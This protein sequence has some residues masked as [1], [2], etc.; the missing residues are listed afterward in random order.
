MSFSAIRIFSYML[1]IV[2]AAL[3]LPFVV[4]CR[5]GEERAALAFGIPM[6]ASWICA[7]AFRW[8][9][10]GRV[11]AIGIEDAFLVVGG[12]WIV[13]GLFG[14]LPFYLSGAAGSVTDAVF[15]SVS[16]FT[17][18][19]ATVMRDVEALPRCV[20]LWRCQ[21]H[22]L[23]GMGV[24]AL[25]VALIPLLG[26][27]GFRMIKAETTG[28]EKGKLTSRIATTAKTLWTV[29]FLFTLA[30]T[31]LLRRFGM[32][33]FDA[34]CHAFSTMGTGGFSTYNDSVGHFGSA[35]IDWTCTAFMLLASVNFTLYFNLITGRLREVF[36]DSEFR[37]FL[38]IVAAAISAVALV[39]WRDYGGIAESLRYSSFQVASI[40]S[41]TGFATAD[42]VQW[43]PA[44]QMAL[45][46][47]FL[48]GGCAGSTAGGI[49][50]VRWTIL[51]KQL[52]NE[53]RRLLHPHE[54][55]SIRING[56]AGRES[57]VPLVASF[58]FVYVSLAA[59]TA[60]FGALSGLGLVEALSGALSMVGNIGPA[61]GG[62]GPTENCASLH[63]ALKWWYSFVMIAGRLEIY[64][65]LILV[66]RAIRRR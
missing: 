54:V 58:I 26:E 18:T 64:T 52:R 31:L 1:A 37:G 16:G 59:V 55:M 19:G 34:V 11:R 27:G 25:A 21:T 56:V 60:F 6:A 30:Q 65:L 39:E 17:T 2:G 8:K 40:V 36:L 61:F 15:E 35:A 33:W 62:L 46:L 5:Y 38:V 43:C 28:P 48:V 4:G 50:V 41:T 22:W 12:I 42:Y 49:K 53:L 7:L 57:F 24:I 51:W 20:N 13:I 63:W 23:G 9:R 66:G 29:Y 44:A 47:L 32:S 14:A 45:F 3:L 10:K